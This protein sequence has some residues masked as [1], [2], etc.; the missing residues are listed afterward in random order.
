M[1]TQLQDAIGS[2]SSTSKFM[3]KVA[4]LGAFF[5]WCGSRVNIDFVIGGVVWISLALVT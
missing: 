4:I 5:L 3:V 1:H 2:F